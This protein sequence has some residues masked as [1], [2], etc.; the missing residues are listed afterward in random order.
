MGNTGVASV[1]RPRSRAS[2]DAIFAACRQLFNEK[3]YGDV[4]IESIA[5]VAGVG[6]ATIY[7]WWPNKLALAV[8]VLL[9]QLHLPEF[10]Y[11]GQG[12]KRHLL[13]GLKACHDNMLKGELAHV[14]S[15]VVA[16]CH[17]DDKLREQFYEGFFAKLREVGMRDLA[18]AIELG[19]L[20]QKLDR[21]VFLDQLF[22]CLYYRVLIA[23]KPVDDAYLHTLL[24]NLLPEAG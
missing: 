24:D 22:G 12:I 21:E 13:K 2:R 5:S 14:I 16:D 17:R 8:D 1:G 20:P 4:S 3:P 15:G 18:I 19:Q 10:Q 6:K 11:R 9:E 7:R 23:N